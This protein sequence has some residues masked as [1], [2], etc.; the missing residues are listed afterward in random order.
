MD[1]SEGVSLLDD[2]DHPLGAPSKINV[3]RGNLCVL[4]VCVFVPLAMPSSLFTPFHS[5][6]STFFFLLFVTGF[7][8]TIPSFPRY[9]IMGSEE[10]GEHN[11]RIENATL[12]DDAEYQCQV[13][14]RGLSKPIRADAQLT[15]LSKSDDWW[16]RSAP[17]SAEAMKT[18]SCLKSIW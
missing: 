17:G 14:P 15:V 12:D 4:R 3:G 6:C 13:G 11:I 2:L 10:Q 1:S 16:L 8:R 5:G 9:T 18:T 7:E